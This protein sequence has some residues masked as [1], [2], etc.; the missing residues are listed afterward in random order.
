MLDLFGD[1][2]ASSVTITLSPPVAYLEKDDTVRFVAIVV[3]DGDTLDVD[4]AWF[5]SDTLKAQVDA[6][7]LV[8]AREDGFAVL[9][10]MW[11]GG[12]SGRPPWWATRRLPWR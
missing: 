9:V 10:A 8:T 4:V 6:E 12:P 5:V 11:G 1:L 3:E 2:D 7:G